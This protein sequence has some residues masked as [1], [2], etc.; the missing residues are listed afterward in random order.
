M[1][2]HAVV[3]A[4]LSAALLGIGGSQAGRRDVEPTGMKTSLCSRSTRASIANASDHIQSRG[5][6]LSM[7]HL[8]IA[9]RSA[10]PE[11][12]ATDVADDLFQL[13]PAKGRV[14]RKAHRAFVAF[15][16]GRSSSTIVPST[17]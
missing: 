13:A 10:D 7:R 14:N 12:A 15:A 2:Y 9:G 8:R 11:D 4:L 3:L 16:F 5:N 6:S 1:N 17:K